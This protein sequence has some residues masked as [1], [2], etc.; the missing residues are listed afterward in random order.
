MIRPLKK[1]RDRIGQT[2]LFLL[3]CDGTIYRGAKLVPGA[4]RFLE[5]LRRKRIPFCFLTNNT[6][7][8]ALDYRK[9][10]A[11]FGIRTGPENVFTAGQAA[12]IWLA[13]KK[14]G[15]RLFVVGTAALKRELARYSLAI[16]DGQGRVDFV[17]AGFDTE[18]TYEKI[19]IACD[20]L[21]RGVPYVATN[22]DAVCPV[23]NGRNLPDCGSLCC[24]L[25]RATGRTP[26][27]IGKP[28]PDMIRIVC[29]KQGVP[30]GRTTLVGDRLYTDIAAGRN[31][32]VFTV[33]VLSGEATRESIARS[34]IKPDCIAESINDLNAPGIL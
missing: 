10:L 31:A 28:R 20:L 26:Y 18:L 32:G 23:E 25:E 6:S 34:P 8:R 27:V 29:E 2:R 1:C 33:C 7:K 22:P 21:S 30:S 16:T 12:G 4:G 3:D 24:M 19:R 5:T 11:G 15:A 9:K 13:R 14:R 17:V